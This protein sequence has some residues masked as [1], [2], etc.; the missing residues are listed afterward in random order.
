[1]YEARIKILSVTF[2]RAHVEV[3]SE[4]VTSE[5]ESEQ[6]LQTQYND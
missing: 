5:V 3:S 2:R 1:M 4:I 6:R